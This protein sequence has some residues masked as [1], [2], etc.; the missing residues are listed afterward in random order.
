MGCVRVGQ[1]QDRTCRNRRCSGQCTGARKVQGDL[2][3]T[4]PLILLQGFSL[5]ADKEITAL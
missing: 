3:L 2:E 5:L 4:W 1:D